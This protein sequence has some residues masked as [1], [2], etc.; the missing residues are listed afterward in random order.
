MLQ[1][2]LIQAHYAACQDCVSTGIKK[3]YKLD[4]CL[5]ETCACKAIQEKCIKIMQN[6]T[7]VSLKTHI[8]EWREKGK[9]EIDGCTE[10]SKT[11]LVQVFPRSQDITTK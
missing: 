9:A 1:W 6:K 5:K 7:V 3:I 4:Y 10:I 11:I 8:N 2:T